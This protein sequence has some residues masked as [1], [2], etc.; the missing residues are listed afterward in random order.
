MATRSLGTRT[1]LKE[2]LLCRLGAAA[3]RLE[4]VPAGS[5]L[6]GGQRR[7]SRS[8]M[9]DDGVDVEGCAFVGGE[10][11]EVFLCVVAV[12]FVWFGEV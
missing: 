8:I 4:A 7:W 1:R 3:A 10:L 6:P 12:A 9:G 5:F 11:C 2:H